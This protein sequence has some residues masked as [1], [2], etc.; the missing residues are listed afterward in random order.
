MIEPVENSDELRIR[1]AQE[2]F[3]SGK[4]G[5]LQEQLYSALNTE[6]WHLRVGSFVDHILTLPT[7]DA[8]TNSIAEVASLVEAQ[9]LG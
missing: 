3:E 1:I 4:Y 2:L 9:A 5:N 8:S 6:H 7:R